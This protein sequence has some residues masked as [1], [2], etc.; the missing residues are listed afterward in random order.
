MTMSEAA[1]SKIPG[2]E[3]LVSAAPA[4]AR[5]ASAVTL[6]GQAEEREGDEPQR[7]SFARL[8]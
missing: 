6:G 5:I 7:G 2:S 1:A 3:R 4:S 8:P